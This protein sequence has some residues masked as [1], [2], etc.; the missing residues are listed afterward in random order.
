MSTLAQKPLPE[1][2]DDRLWKKL[3][4]CP[5]CGAKSFHRII[6]AR[7]WHYGNPG[8]FPVMRCEVCGVHFLNPMPT[9]AYLSTAYPQN[10]YAYRLTK[11][12]PFQKRLRRAVRRMLFFTVGWTGDA[13][14]AKPGCMLDIGCGAGDFI[15]EMREKGWEVHGVELDTAAA[16][17]GKR[18]GLDIFAGT[19]HDAHFATGAFDYVRSNHSFEHIHNPREVLREIRR[20]IRPNGRLFIGV[21]NVTG[22]MSRLWGTYWWYVGAPVH[23]F[24]YT[25][26]SLSRLLSNEGFEVE[27]VKYNSNF[28][29]VIGSL[30][31]WLNRDSGRLSEEGPVYQS[32]LLRLI[33]QWLARFIDLFHAGDCIEVIARPI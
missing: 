16:A 30:Q 15:S 21:P 13:T 17:R 32:K 27:T 12:S 22:L 2:T 8:I 4:A 33:G 6:N 10:Y 11:H 14:F 23:T 24:G 20:I 3:S 25:P 7:D 5:L 18:E 28:G 1:L 26:A 29:G 19:V 9:L 31:I